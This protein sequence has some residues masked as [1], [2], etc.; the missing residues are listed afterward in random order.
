MYNNDMARV[1][2]VN[3]NSN[4]IQIRLRKP[5]QSAIHLSSPGAPFSV[6]QG[7][8]ILPLVIANSKM[9]PTVGFRGHGWSAA[10]AS[11]GDVI[12]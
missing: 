2:I 8:G 9:V 4:W 1:S 5:F 3:F 7:P 12:E 6:Q 10:E 11:L